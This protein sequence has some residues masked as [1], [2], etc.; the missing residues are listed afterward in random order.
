VSR[1]LVRLTGPDTFPFLQG[2]ITNDISHVE[3]PDGGPLYALLLN[4]QGRVLYDVIIYSQPGQTLLECDLS[5]Q[6]Q[7]LKHLTLYRVKKKVVIAD[8]STDLSPWVVFKSISDTHTD[9]TE[10]KK[11]LRIG[12]HRG[13]SDPRLSDLGWRFYVPRGQESQLNSTLTSVSPEEYKKLRYSLG[14]GE[15]VQDIPIAGSF[16]LESNGDYLHGIS[17]HKGCY[18]GQELTARTHHTGVVRK[19]LMPFGLPT[20]AGADKFPSDTDTSKLEIKTQ[21]GKSVGKVRGIIGEYGL[22]LTRVEEALSAKDGLKI[23]DLTVSV[24]KPNWWPIELPKTL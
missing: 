5:I 2:L 19:R 20:G 10:K 4:H 12:D 17:F 15:G 3:G 9:P 16:P 6:P 11:E 24:K 22:A 18:V 8:A 1:A 21:G 14:V 13:I 7:L 23:G